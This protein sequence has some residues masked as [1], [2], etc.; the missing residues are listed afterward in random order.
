[1]DDQDRGIV[2]GCHVVVHMAATYET[3]ISIV[4]HDIQH[5][6]W[7]KIHTC[8]ARTSGQEKMY[9]TEYS[10]CAT[11]ELTIYAHVYESIC[12]SEL[13]EY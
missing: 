13:K 12:D 6:A 5:S 7:Q 10:A 9:K 11:D 4:L 1:M 2:C 8:N 3:P